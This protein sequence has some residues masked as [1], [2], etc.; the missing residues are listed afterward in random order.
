MVDRVTPALL[1]KVVEDRWTEEHEV[2]HRS[3]LDACLAAAGAEPPQLYGYHMED[4]LARVAREP[5]AA[6]QGHR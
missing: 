2:H 6:G 3:Q 4:V 5:A 1:T